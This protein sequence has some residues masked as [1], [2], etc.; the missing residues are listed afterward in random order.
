MTAFW[1]L[2]P[3][4]VIAALGLIFARKAVHAALALAVVMISLAIL[5]A[6]QGA[7][8]LFAVQIIVYTGAI[9]MLFLFVLMLV[10]VD[11][12][13]AIRE[14]IAG[15]RFFAAVVGLLFGITAVLA[16][17]QTVS[18]AV[19]GL[20]GA[21]AN[22]NPYGLAELLF[23]KYVL[24]FEFTSALLITAALGAMV[25]AHKERLTP[26]LSQADIA[27][28]R[29]REYAESGRHLAPQATPGVFARHNA[30]DTPALLPDGTPLES[31]L[32][33]SIVE[34]GQVRSGFDDDIDKVVEQLTPEE[35]PDALGGQK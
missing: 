31:S 14:T 33:P 15:Q 30:V 10:G 2:A 17:G 29:M 35:D 9:M 1:V 4:M 6:A 19:V 12:S 27:A 16:I 20:K 25:L 23:G 28:R 26:R 5:Y 32:S 34:R 13:D 21:N 24:A 18:G 11:S 8:F 7:P 22:G 3:V